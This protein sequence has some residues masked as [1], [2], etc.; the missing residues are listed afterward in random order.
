MGRALYAFEPKGSLYTLYP[1]NISSA[2]SPESTTFTY[3][4]AFLHT[5]YRAM[6]EGSARGSSIWYCIFGMFSQYSSGVMTLLMFSLP[7]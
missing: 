3:S 7:M 1:P 5:K 2:P 4:D 6:Q